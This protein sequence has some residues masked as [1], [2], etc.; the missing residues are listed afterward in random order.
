MHVLGDPLIV[1][2]RDKST[3]PVK[4]TLIA[5]EPGGLLWR[6]EAYSPDEDVWRKI[7]DPGVRFT[8]WDLIRF[9]REVPSAEPAK[10]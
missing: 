6:I 8:P 9:V 2:Y 5:R 7:P 4:G 1:V 3:F 10:A